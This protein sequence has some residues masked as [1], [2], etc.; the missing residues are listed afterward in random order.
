MTSTMTRM[1]TRYLPTALAALLL[2]ACSGED[3]GTLHGYAEGDYVYAAAITGGRVDM[4]HVREGAHV[5]PGDLLFGL[6]ATEA[7]A[8]AAEAEAR[9]AN[10]EKGLRPEDL[11]IIDARIARA[12]AARA[13][14]A[15]ELER[16][17][18]LA[19][20]DA[21][22]RARLQQA[23]AAFAEADAALVEAKAQRH[24]ATLP[25]RDDELAAARAQ[26]DAAHHAL[27]E[28]EVKAS[29]SATIEDIIV[30]PGEV[31]NAGQP[32]LA[33]LPDDAIKLRLFAAEPIIAQLRPGME[34]AVSCDGCA[35]GLTATITFI[36]SRAEYTP[37]VIYSDE[38]RAKLVFLVEAR[39]SDPSALRPGLPVT[40]ERLP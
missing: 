37:P 26:T 8:R 22:A 18:T 16:Q 13:L 23:E 15:V 35:E 4:I 32:V 31:A 36:S 21:G 33:L 11:A 30:Q 7:R 1:M 27:A 2:A 5:E 40:A 20:S 14:A 19:R 17:R 28:R 12:D 39:P 29:A 38:E 25:A 3:V 10:L 24:V 6:D 34:L 9:L